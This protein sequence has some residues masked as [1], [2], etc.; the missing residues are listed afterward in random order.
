MFYHLD[1]LKLR[2]GR[3]SVIWLAANGKLKWVG[4][5]TAKDRRLLLS[6]KVNITR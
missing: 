6:V 2:N 3:F 5:G 4:R 1:M